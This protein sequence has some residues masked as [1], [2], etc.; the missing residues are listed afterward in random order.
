[1]TQDASLSVVNAHPKRFPGV[2]LLHQLV[3]KTNSDPA[4]EHLQQQQQQQPDEH[5][6]A[7][8]STATS[9]TTTTI[10]TYAELHDAADRLAVR[11]ASLCHGEKRIVPVLVHQSPLLYISLLAILKAGSA[12]CPVN[13]DAPPERLRFILGDVAAPL[14]LTTTAL[15]GNIPA[16]DGVEILL[17]DEFMSHSDSTLNG[18][19]SLLLPEAKPTDLA[20]VMYT[21]GSTGTPKG[22]GVSH[23]AATQAFYAHNQ[24]IPA[25]EKFFQFASPT[26]DVSVFEIFFPL[27]RGAIL[28]SA[29]RQLVLDDLV[30]VFKVMNI[31]ACELTPTVASA[32][33]RLRSRAPSLKLL[34]TIGEMLNQQVVQEFGGSETRKSLLYAMYGPTE[35]T[36]HCTLQPNFSAS[37]S[38]RTIGVPLDTVSC[39]VIRPDVP[40]ELVPR[41]VEGELAVGGYQL[42]DGYINR[43]EQTSAVFIDSPYGRVYRTGDRAIMRTDGTLECLGRLSSGQVKLRGQRLELGEVEHAIMKTHGCHGAAAAVVGSILVAFCAVDSDV[44]VSDILHSCNSWLPRFMVPGDVI[45]MESLP[46]LPSGKTDVKALVADYEQRLKETTATDI[47]LNGHDILTIL[48]E[49]VHSVVSRTMTPAMAGIDSLVAIRVASRIRAAGYDISAHQLLTCSRIGDLCNITKSIPSQKSEKQQLVPTDVSDAIITAQSAAF[50]ENQIDIVLPCTSVQ[51]AMLSQSAQNPASYWNLVEYELNTLLPVEAIRADLITAIKAHQLLRGSFINH[52]GGFYI[53]VTKELD[54]SCLIT[55]TTGFAT[56]PSTSIQRPLQI[57]IAA[58]GHGFAHKLRLDLHHALYDGWSLDLF[59]SD[60]SQLIHGHDLPSRHSFQ[61]V[62]EQGPI[63]PHV[64][65]T[66]FWAEYLMA[67]EKPAVPKLVHSIS[68]DTTPQITQYTLPL[69]PEKLKQTALQEG[70]TAQCYFQAALAMVWSSICH[71]PDLVLGSVLSGRDANIANVEYIFGPMIKTLPLRLII[72]KENTIQQLLDSVQSSNLNLLENASIPLTEISKISGMVTGDSMFDV[73]FAYQ[74]SPYPLDPAIGKE[75]RHVDYTD[76]RIILEAIPSKDDFTLQLTYHSNFC[77]DSLSKEILH[78]V[79]SLVSKFAESSLGQSL[80]SLM[81][82]LPCAQSIYNQQPTT[83]T[84]PSNLAQLV[85]IASTKYSDEIAIEFFQSASATNPISTTIS[86]TELNASSNQVARWLQSEGVNPGDIVPIIMEKSTDLYVN[87]LGIVKAGCSYLPLLPNLP[88][89]RMSEVIAQAEATFCICDAESAS[90]VQE[91]ERA[92]VLVPGTAPLA[93]YS[94][95]NLKLEI[96]ST[97]L[98][99]IVYTS[100]TTGKPKGVAVSHKSIVSNVIQLQE[101]YPSATTGQGRLLQACSQAFDVSVFEIFHAWQTGM[102]LC[103]AVNDV[104]FEDLEQ[105][106]RAFQ[107]TH[108]SLTP[109]VASLIAAENVPRVEFLVTAGEPLSQRV[110]QNWKG[111]LWQGYGPSETTNICTVKRMTGNEHMDH[112]GWTFPNTSVIV[113]EAG[114]QAALPVGWVGEFCYGGDQIASGYLNMPEV[115]EQKFI[116]HA[117]YGRLYR[118][119]DMGR[120]LSD[121]SLVILGRLDDQIKLRGQ[122]IEP[123]EINSVISTNDLVASAETLLMRGGSQSR[124]MLVSF[125]VGLQES[126]DFQMLETVLELNQEIFSRLKA[127]L[128]S[129]MVPTYLFAVSCLPLTPTGKVDKNRLREAVHLCSKEQLAAASGATDSTEDESWSVLETLLASALCSLYNVHRDEVRRWT[130]FSTLGLDSISA[131]RFVFHLKEA[132]H[133]SVSISMILQNPTVAQLAIAIDGQSN[134]KESSEVAFF[135]QTAMDDIQ[136]RSQERLDNIISVMPCLPLQGAMLSQGKERY[137]NQILL[138]LHIGEDLIKKHWNTVIERHDIFRTHFITTRSSAYPI[139]QVVTKTAKVNWEHFDVDALSLDGVIAEHMNKLPDPVDSYE[140]PYSLGIIRY[141]GSTFLSFI[142]HHALYDGVAMENLYRE[143]EHLSNG[144]ILAPSISSVPFL[145]QALELP[146]DADAFWQSHFEGYQPIFISAK[147]DKHITSQSSS[148]MSFDTTLSDLQSRC[149]DLGISLLSLCQSAWAMVLAVIS[150]S[151]DVCFGNVMS[152]RTVA[153]EGVERILAPC[154]NT[155]PVRMQIDARQTPVGLARAFQT[156]NSKLLKYQFTP[157]RLVNKITRKRNLFDTLLLVQQPLTDMDKS[158]WTLEADNGSMDVPIVC[159]VTPCPNLNSLVATI[160]YDMV[161]VTNPA[162]SKLTE[163]LKAA[164]QTVLE[165]PTNRI[166]RRMDLASSLQ[167][168]FEDFQTRKD[169]SEDVLSRQDD[170][171]MLDSTTEYKTVVDILSSLADVPSSR[172]QPHTSIFQLGLDSISAVQIAS[173]LRS[174]GFKVSSADII[175]LQN[176]HLIAKKLQQTPILLDDNTIGYDFAAFNTAV[177]SQI[178]AAI[179]QTANTADVLPATPMQCSMLSLS[180][181]SENFSYINVITT[182]C[183]SGITADELRQAWFTLANKLPILRA[184]FVD[185]RHP[186]TTHAMVQ[187]IPFDELSSNSITELTEGSIEDAILSARKSIQSDLTHPPW[188]VILTNTNSEQITMALVIHH[189]LYDASSLKSIMMDLDNALTMTPISDPQPIRSGLSEMLQWANNSS[190]T[191]AETFWTSKSDSIAITKFPTM[192][193]L[194]EASSR[195]LTTEFTTS[196]TI[197]QLQ[198]W[199][200]ACESTIQASIQAAWTRVLSSYLGENAVTFGQV[201][202]GRVTESTA[203]T[204]LPCLAT[205]P[206]IVQN[207]SS[208]RELLQATLYYS[209]EIQRY[210]FSPL[211]NI[212]KWLG[213]PATALFDTAIAYQRLANESSKPTSW[214]VIGDDAA[215]EFPISLEVEAND[216]SAEAFFIMRLTFME[217]VMPMEQAQLMVQQFEASWVHLLSEP[218]QTQDD[219]FQ[220]APHVFAITNPKIPIMSAPVTLL[221]QFVEIAAASTPDN[222]ALE[223]V[224]E[225]DDDVCKTKTWTYQELNSNGNKIAHLLSQHTNPGDIVAIHFDKCPEAY[226]SILGILKA[227]CGFVAL[228]INAPNSRKEFILGDSQAPCMLSLA[229]IDF[230]VPSSCN[231]LKIEES[232]LSDLP[233]TAPIIDIAPESTCYCLYTS[234]TTGTPKGCLISHENTVQAMMAFQELFDGHWD[235]ESKCLQFASLHFDVSVLEQY[236]SW[237]VGITMVAAPKDLILNDIT[238]SINALNITHIDLTPSLARLVHPDTV[239][240]LCRG[241]FIT[242][243]E[244][245]KQEILDDWGPAGVIYNA[246][247][248]TEA[249]IGVTMY[250][251]VPQNGRPS[252]IGRQFSNVGSIVVQK[253]TEKPVLRGGVG[254]LCVYGKL[255][256]TGYLNRP[257]L[258]DEKFPT[259]K[260]LNERVYRTGDMVRILHD[261]CFDFLGRADD[262]VK[263]RGQRLEIGEINHCIRS[264]CPS[265]QDAATIVVKHGTS[266]KDV[267]V[268]FIV[269]RTTNTSSKDVYTMAD[270]NGLLAEARTACRDKLPGYMV[271]TFFIRISR[272]PLS[273]N[274]KLEAKELRQL[275]LNLDQLELMSLTSTQSQSTSSISTVLVKRIAEFTS[276]DAALITAETSLFDLGLD[277]ISIVQLARYLRQNGFPSA[278]PPLLL[279]NSMVAD[280]SAALQKDITQGRSAKVQ[281]TRQMIRAKFHKYLPAAHAALGIGPDRIEYICPCSGLQQGIIARSMIASQS[282]AYFNSFHL[283]LTNGVDLTQLKQ[284]WEALIA[285]EAILRTSFIHTSDGFVQVAEKNKDLFWEETELDKSTTSLDNVIEEYRTHWIASNQTVIVSPLRLLL[286][287]H[288]DKRILVIFMH[289]SIYDGKS[290]DTMLRRISNI[291][292]GQTPL[293]APSFLDALI[294]GPLTSDT[295]AEPRWKSYLAGCDFSAID[296]PPSS[297]DKMPISISRELNISTL[298]DLRKKYKVTL[299]SIVLS[300]WTS[301]FWKRFGGNQSIGIVLSGRSVPDMNVDDTIG[302]MFNTLPFF[303]KA[304]V[305]QSW[306]ALIQECHQFSIL[307]LEDEHVSLKNI[308]KWC[309]HGLPIFDTLFAYEVDNTDNDS[310]VPWTIGPSSGAIDYPLAFEVINMQNHALKLTLAT[311][312]SFID[313]STAESIL[314]DV[315]ESINDILAN[316]FVPIVV[317]S[318]PETPD[319]LAQTPTDNESSFVHSETSLIIRSQLSLISRTP[320]DEIKATTLFTELGL[321]SVDIIQLVGRLRKHGISLTATAV[322]KAQSIANM[323]SMLDRNHL[324]SNSS[325]SSSWSEMQTILNDLLTNAGSDIEQIL[326]ATSV[327]ESMIAGMLDSDFAYYFNQAVFKLSD[328]VDVDKLSTAWLQLVDQCP[329]LRTG[330]SQVTDARLD[331]AYCQTIYQPSVFKPR[332]LKI[333]DRAEINTLLSQ[334]KGLAILGCGERDLFQVTFAVLGAQKYMIVSLCH[335]LYD[336]WSLDLIY[337]SLTA[338][339]NNQ[340]PELNHNTEALFLAHAHIDKEANREFWKGHLSN[341]QPS[342]IESLVDMDLPVDGPHREEHEASLPFSQLSSFCKDH[343][344][345]LQTLCHAVWASVLAK[346]TSSLDVCFGIVHSGRDFEG[347]ETLVFPTMNTLPF[348]CVIH[349]TAATFLAYLEETMQEIRQYQSYPL[350][351]ALSAAE[352]T[353]ADSFNTLFMLQKTQSGNQSQPLFTAI[354]GTSA[355]EYPVCAEAEVVDDKLVWRVACLTGNTSSEMAATIIADLEHALHSIVTDPN[356]EML[357]FTVTGA[358]ILGWPEFQLEDTLHVDTQAKNIEANPAF[359]WS[360]DSLAIRQVLSQVSN[361]E[362]EAIEPTSNLFQ[363]GLDSISAIKVSSLLKGQGIKLKPR[364]LIKATSIADMISAL[365]IDHMD[366]A[367]IANTSET[368]WVVPDTINIDN[369]LA[370]FSFM[371]DHVEAVLPASALQVYMVN[372]WANN[373]GNV[374]YPTFTYRLTAETTIAQI[375]SAW[376]EVVKST[377]MLRTVVL[378]TANENTPMI[379]IILKYGAGKPTPFVAFSVEAANDGFDIS[380]RIHHAL[381]DAISLDTII[382]RLRQAIQSQLPSIN[383][384]LGRWAVHILHTRSKK[385]KSSTKA[386]WSSYLANVSANEYPLINIQQRSERVSLFI[387]GA[388]ADATR[389]QQTASQNSLSIQSLLFAAYARQTSA[390]KQVDN[391]SAVVIGIYMA[392]RANSTDELNTY[393]TLNLIPL[394]VVNKSDLVS[395]ASQIQADLLDIS[396]EQ[397]AHVSLYDIYRWTGVQVDSFVNFLPSPTEDAPADSSFSIIESPL[398]TPDLVTKQDTQLCRAFLDNS[399]TS[400]A[401]P[402]ALDVEA[403]IRDGAMDI[404]VFGPSTRITS[405]EAQTLITE[406]VEI[407]HNL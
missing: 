222:I 391:G 351:K 376:E 215:V 265:I 97:Q 249:T 114:G 52:D 230:Q 400:N 153:V 20:Y 83:I 41:E 62:F 229:A 42:A 184:G 71:A 189:A 339:Y 40:F 78:Q 154:F 175:E 321:D 24:H 4:L 3:S 299:Q 182:L 1:M 398:D 16:V 282:G 326:P 260:D 155:V 363:L 307:A 369:I 28:A 29:D 210:Q 227:G 281:Q 61:S 261:G 36:I 21:S 93:T 43:P 331:M 347:A 174:Q 13:L 312:L 235:A 298:E 130:L 284:A 181:T 252:N 118:S 139:A 33:L 161:T 178:Q 332:K 183:N 384:T 149:K 94:Q 15:S 129:Y 216:D 305:A 135:D 22:V 264:H 117:T 80:S 288:S 66:T 35:A 126:R 223:Y 338:L 167:S 170:A 340:Q 401:F 263:L 204:P 121:G 51:S 231:I 388:V 27:F 136:S 84:S 393:P 48:S 7:T 146:Y 47:A 39:F 268:A 110:L 2:Y 106:I 279:K 45:V 296:S 219:L 349:G 311:T 270:E 10:T 190:S 187:Y 336:G 291:M 77:T 85:E 17:L 262:Q 308:Q 14:V 193:P 92:K 382:S 255:V 69:S 266:G 125:Y 208:N 148:S 206:I 320:E 88:L 316:R 68:S 394:K 226:F 224:V 314:D 192:T 386:F 119:G 297:A 383:S 6:N 406:L 236:W 244:Q 38:R 138:R 323:M 73:M 144:Q 233:S 12:F 377:P 366:S 55:T 82:D 79:A 367:P 11:I 374:F 101:I 217:N 164:F 151:D 283:H 355:V 273:A 348:R 221:H 180:A 171:E 198:T 207:M 103:A 177:Q 395:M 120:M 191:E 356:T 251:R 285:E 160:R 200:T 343:R 133:L 197:G 194:R 25:F 5:D 76:T 240:S 342:L 246:Y 145:Q 385:Q 72:Q 81:R 218:D 407:L 172:I 258:T 163:L 322:L 86:Y 91:I 98:A 310:D 158:V 134:G 59:M 379:Q 159:E 344:I 74:E 390:A 365:A 49:M 209:T 168:G 58:D 289:H 360:K 325:N 378:P 259:F 329:I 324:T 65:Q 303:P 274:N 70:Y 140:A 18:G 212:Q 132:L 63:Q 292:K 254:E 330:F 213:H 102:R 95:E 147:S 271:P 234:G 358:S 75:T 186:D 318:E 300:L 381:Y 337:S 346:H 196:K 280:T 294:H 105:A 328:G 359:E 327:Q 137:Y 211:Q 50:G 53:V 315:E 156:L 317:S 104:L 387:K 116:N 362:V 46:R 205:I 335:A 392:N 286:V 396:A 141:R 162:A 373:L 245:L 368:T 8:F 228:D 287:K 142:C 199:A 403:C 124:D 128:T 361:I 195:I 220:Y 399:C 309:S 313:K 56:P 152:G 122:R 243:G 9:T 57:Q 157:L 30:H 352:V 238:R 293:P 225:L 169:R 202:S 67:W 239:P 301:V 150:D 99:Y 127:T 250:Q 111:R 87:I 371:Q 232:G 341:L 34:L 214:T 26:F 295:S 37:A 179:S 123:S 278:T 290:L 60:F 257:E 275:F 108:L 241:V 319:E 397:R 165:Q 100:G 302:P 267:L 306:D 350:R 242:G 32:L 19:A 173:Q 54:T 248:P 357:D 90:K 370:K 272:I 131:I 304:Q 353:G 89:A 143:I 334:D 389:L 44:D 380:I 354:D 405:P 247:G 188:R 64:E 176:A 115:T 185:V 269:S 276:M 256:G 203:Q 237:G 31:D 345:T 375:T 372:S 253:D 96:D 277:S 201:L 113:L 402:Y 166:P 23:D 333:S 109:T 112:L 404:G 107:I 364:D